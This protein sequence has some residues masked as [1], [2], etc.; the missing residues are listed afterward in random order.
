MSRLTP[1]HACHACT[2]QSTRVDAHDEFNSGRLPSNRTKAATGIPRQAASQARFFGSA[3][4]AETRQT[5]SKRTSR[6]DN[7]AYE[8]A[9]TF[10]AIVLIY[11]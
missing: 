2:T 11:R 9:E 5:N 1:P 6:R 10:G 8:V 4:D 3:L 7:D